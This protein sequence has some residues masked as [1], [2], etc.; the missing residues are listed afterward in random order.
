M[1]SYVFKVASMEV[2]KLKELLE[3][4]REGDSLLVSSSLVTGTIFALVGIRP[5][6]G[7]TL[8]PYDE[9][10][11][12][13]KDIFGIPLGEF[14]ASCGC[15]FKGRALLKAC[16][17]HIWITKRSMPKMSIDEDLKTAYPNT[18]VVS[19]NHF[20]NWHSD[21]YELCAICG[22]HNNH[23]GVPHGDAT[24]DHLTRQDIIDYLDGRGFRWSI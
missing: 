6:E 3:N 15:S 4:Y 7:E 13:D 2:D 14:K 11:T 21:L 24:G 9:V 18:P 17:Q 8:G 12:V 23:D 1:A 20:D 10:L 22:A 16:E 19:V 5:P